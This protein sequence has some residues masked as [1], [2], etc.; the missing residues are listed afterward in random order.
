MFIFIYPAFGCFVLGYQQ[1]FPSF[2]L[3]TGVTVHYVCWKNSLDSSES[4][5]IYDFCK[6]MTGTPISKINR[7]S[8]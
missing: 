7:D 3:Q 6:E 2:P 8:P 5:V 1:S 4:H